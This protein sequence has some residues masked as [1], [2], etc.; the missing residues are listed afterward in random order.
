M[1][2]HA[3]ACRREFRALVLTA[4]A[5]LLFAGRASAQTP[6]PEPV[7][8]WDVQ[9]GAAFV[10][11]TGNSDTSSF[12]A[13]FEAHRRWPV[14]IFDAVATAVN[15]TTD[16]EQTAAQYIAGMRIRRKLSER[17]S[18]TSGLRFERDVIAGI[19]LRSMIDGGLTY[20]LIKQP[21]WTL[22]GLT[23][24]AWVHEDRITG[25]TKDSAEGVLTLL[26]KYTFASGE[27]TQRFT[28]FPNFT[29]STGYR[30]EAEITVQAAMNKKLALKFGFLWRYDHDPVPDHK[31]S[32]TTTTAS[33]VVRWRSETPAP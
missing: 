15:T 21:Q 9:L 7:P 24:I 5:L 29:D 17:I 30:S 25:E 33:I 3:I 16:G 1:F 8:L 2:T 27:T 13:N 14:W 10:G 19:D 31:R 12:G 28:F 32:D 18:A 20:A 22:D 11:T 6:P 23:S 26:D 4:G